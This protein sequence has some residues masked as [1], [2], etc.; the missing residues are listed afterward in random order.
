VA[1]KNEAP[2]DPHRYRYRDASGLK[3]G[4]KSLD[5]S[6]E[7]PV[8]ADPR[9]DVEER[10]EATEPTPGAVA[11]STVDDGGPDPDALP[12]GTIV[13]AYVVRHL[14]ASGGGG[15]VFLAEHTSRGHK[16]AIKVL[17]TEVARSP[18]GLARFQREARMVNLIRHPAIVDIREFGQLVDGR[19][20][21]VMELLEGCDLK[22]MIK[23]RGRFAA[24]EMLQIVE[25]ICSALEAAHS[26]G[27]VH[28]DLKASN[29]HVHEKDGKLEVKLLDFG[30]AK[31]LTP[32]PS[33]GGLTV[34]GMRLGTAS[35]MA[36]EQIRGDAVD[37]RTDVYALGV[38][39][40]HLLTGRY[41]F[42]ADTRQEI[43]RMNLEAPPPRPS[44]IAAVP[45]AIDMV[46]LRC[47]D[48]RPERRYAS[49]REVVTA[50]HEALDGRGQ[51]P[52]DG[53]SHKAAVAVY[54]SVRAA[55]DQGLDEEELLDQVA[56]V[57][58]LA[59][60]AL[61]DGGFAVP[62]HTGNAVLGARVLPE[63]AAA[64]RIDRKKALD[65]AVVLSRQIAQQQGGRTELV[66]DVTLHSDVA[67]VRG[68]EI[69]GAIV[70]VSRWPAGNPWSGISAT[71]EGVAEIDPTGTDTVSR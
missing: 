69:G 20:Y 34:A 42:R 21:F 9:Q 8:A 3:A 48:K 36:P 16:V 22:Q 63:D 24:E 61:N 50:L 53:T 31:L 29:V 11:L 51:A 39:I 32:D 44:Q 41:P 26:A 14:I 68:S 27:V 19:P 56:E 13:G 18:M 54:V 6:G 33:M 38:L 17:R 59:E 49:V 66:I 23:Q 2:S 64:A 45:P 65:Q 10:T 67:V 15:T 43:E 7:G 60:Q 1:R 35:A 30:I 58:E 12:A 28:R 55:Q 25:P 5:A 47:M 62:L 57:L 70:E 46:V 71:R 37:Q 40:Y 52:A 4:A